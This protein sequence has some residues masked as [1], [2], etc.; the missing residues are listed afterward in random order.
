MSTSRNTAAEGQLLV[1][2]V[3]CGR[4]AAG[5]AEEEGELSQGMVAAEA[6]QRQLEHVGV[7]AVA[8]AKGGRRA[9][10]ATPAII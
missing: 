3:C 7:T 9:H 2:L 5:Q 1:E 10:K 8:L 6:L 4:T